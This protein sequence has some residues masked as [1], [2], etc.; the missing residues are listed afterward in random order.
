MLRAF[1]VAIAFVLSAFGAAGSAQAQS[2]VVTVEVCNRTGVD[3]FLAIA[4]IPVGQRDFVNEG[5]RR[6]NAYQ[7]SRQAE[8]TNSYFYLYAEEV[9]GDGYWGGDF[10]HCVIRPGPFER[11]LVGT[12]SQYGADQV[13]F[14]EIHTNISSGTFTWNLNP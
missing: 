9:G 8:T 13:Q 4:Y 14:E 7:C 12:C 1:F 3:V 6:I 2:N 5:W 11:A 10:D